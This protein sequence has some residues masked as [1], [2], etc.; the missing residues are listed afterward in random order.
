MARKLVP[1]GK[2][3]GQVEPG[4]PTVTVKEGWF[5]LRC[6]RSPENCHDRVLWGGHDRV[7]HVCRDRGG[8]AGRR[9][10]AAV[11]AGRAACRGGAAGRRGRSWRFPDNSRF[12]GLNGNSNSRLGDRQILVKV[13]IRQPILDLYGANRRNFPGYF[14][15]TREF[16]RGIEL[17]GNSAAAAPSDPP[18]LLARLRRLTRSAPCP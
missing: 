9:G 11:A 1:R 15:V 4:K 14:P 3:V 17:N 10:K 13:L 5:S 16:R 6:A 8:V 18:L 12:H 7:R 2:R